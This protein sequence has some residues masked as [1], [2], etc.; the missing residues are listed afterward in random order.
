MKLKCVTVDDEY[1][2]LRILADYI[3]RIPALELTGQF[4][5]P[6]EALIFLRHNPVDI[7]LLDIQMPFLNGIDFIKKLTEKPLVIY[8]T[9]RHDY[10]VEAFELDVLDYL[11]KPIAFER[12]EKAIA[13]AVE[14]LQYRISSLKEK[15]EMN[16]LMIKSDH[17]VIQLS[18][19]TILYIEGLSEYVRIHT[20]EK[21]HITLASLKELEKQLPAWRFLRIHKSY[22]VARNQIASYNS[23]AV[24]LH[25]NIEL[26]VG[27]K[28]KDE[29][30]Q[31]MKAN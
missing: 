13:K 19:D 25:T 10:A 14:Y 8:T 31:I 7:L 18:L 20:A 5:S 27:R 3:N 26:P 11:V 30:L 1:L 6:E 15:Q 21:K 23:S 16:F 2:A 12:F 24:K 17:R 4:K 28:Y 9:A 29:F 22:L